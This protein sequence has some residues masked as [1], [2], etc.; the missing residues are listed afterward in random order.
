MKN[1]TETSV[2][3]IKRI[4]EQQC[5]HCLIKSK[6]RKQKSAFPNLGFPSSAFFHR[7]PV[8]ECSFLFD[9]KMQETHVLQG[10]FLQ[11]NCTNQCPIGLPSIRIAFFKIQFQS[12][13][14]FYFKVTVKYLSKQVGCCSKKCIFW[15]AELCS[16]TSI[17]H[18]H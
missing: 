8:S 13:L 17:T 4:L 3:L 16:R 7:R 15:F 12:N 9:K 10:F 1:Y 14:R 18:Y 11:A 2:C 6:S 5:L